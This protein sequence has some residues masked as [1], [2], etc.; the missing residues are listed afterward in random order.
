M[1]A[2]AMADRISKL[3][4]KVKNH[5]ELANDSYKTAA[6][7]HKCLKEYQVGDLVMA[8]LH[9]S[10]FPAGHHSKMTNKR[11]GPFQIL[12]RPGP[13]A[14]RLDLPATM[15]ISPIIQRFLSFSLPCS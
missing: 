1:E 8:Y 12:E 9:K 6:N 3:N 10:R 15:R 14:Y 5:L 4:Q 7:S 11:I 13:N 2:E